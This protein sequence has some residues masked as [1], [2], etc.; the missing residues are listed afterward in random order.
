[1]G[2]PPRRRWRGCCRRRCGCCSARGGSSLNLRAQLGGHR[3]TALKAAA[4]LVQAAQQVDLRDN[5][6]L[7]A[8]M[9]VLAAQAFHIFGT[10]GFALLLFSQLRCLTPPF[11]S[12]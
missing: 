12:A 5:R 4:M 8:E 10:M 1:M 2:S 11:G 3:Q 9:L 6:I 7:D